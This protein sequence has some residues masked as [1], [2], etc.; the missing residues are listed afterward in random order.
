MNILGLGGLVNDPA[1]A[2]VKDGHLAAAVEQKKIA[3]RYEGG[4]IAA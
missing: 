2:V 1:C 4:R 3:R